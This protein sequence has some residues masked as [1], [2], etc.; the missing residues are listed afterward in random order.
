MPAQLGRWAC[1][2]D[3]TVLASGW[4]QAI[5]LELLH[6]FLLWATNNSLVLDAAQ[7][8][9]TRAAVGRAVMHQLQ[10]AGVQQHLFEIVSNVA[11]RLSAAAQGAL[12]LSPTVAFQNQEPAQ[13]QGC[14]TWPAH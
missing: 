10:G 5:A 11:K 2:V 8:Q 7:G 1:A 13:S 14:L 4:F 6:C 9:P 12:L 3:L